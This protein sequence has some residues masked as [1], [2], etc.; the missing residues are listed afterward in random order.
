MQDSDET[1]D[2][3]L[4]TDILEEIGILNAEKKIRKVSRISK[5]SN[6]Q[7]TNNKP[8]PKIVELREK[9][10]RSRVLKNAKNLK[11]SATFNKCFINLDM[12]RN[13]LAI[14]TE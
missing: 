11:D 14:E 5:N 1:S 6:Q 9:E 10:M 13:E 4:V 3:K 2:E 7:S 12:T 8:S